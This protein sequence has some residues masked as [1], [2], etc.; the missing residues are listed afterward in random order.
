MRCGLYS[1]VGRHDY[2]VRTGYDAPVLGWEE[3]TCS[4][5]D[6]NKMRNTSPAEESSLCPKLS[7]SYEERLKGYISNK[8]QWCEQETND[9]INDIYTSKTPM[10]IQHTTLNAHEETLLTL[11]RFDHRSLDN[12]IRA[13][14]SDS[15]NRS[16]RM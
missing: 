3:A 5:Q 8:T 10:P 2:A 11:L 15:L 9:L 1:E 4:N 12:R 16:R 6:K 13:R 7:C 14:E